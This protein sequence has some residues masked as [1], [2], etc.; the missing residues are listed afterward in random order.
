MNMCGPYPK[1]HAGLVFHSNFS[2]IPL[3]HCILHSHIG[4]LFP[5]PHCSGVARNLLLLPT[6]ITY[7]F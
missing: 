2:Y 5:F 3:L 6:F 7:Q 4:L 1:T